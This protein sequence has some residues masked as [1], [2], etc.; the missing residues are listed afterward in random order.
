MIQ[1]TVL[2]LLQLSIVTSFAPAIDNELV[3]SFELWLS[4]HQSENKQFFCYSSFVYLFVFQPSDDSA[5]GKKLLQLWQKKMSRISR[6][7]KKKESFLDGIFQFLC[8]RKKQ[9]RVRN[10]NNKTYSV[11]FVLIGFDSTVKKTT[12]IHWLLWG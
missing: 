11:S 2:A 4:M 1:V 12:E 7:E 9:K 5:R 6:P 10:S 3:N 8:I